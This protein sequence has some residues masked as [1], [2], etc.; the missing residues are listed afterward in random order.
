MKHLCTLDTDLDE[1][2]GHE[3]QDGYHA[4]PLSQAMRSGEELELIASDCLS[5]L[6]QHKLS[7]LTCGLFIAET[8]ESISPPP[9]FRLVFH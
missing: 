8:G 7:T 9:C 4:G 1:L 2:V 5:P 6:T 3:E